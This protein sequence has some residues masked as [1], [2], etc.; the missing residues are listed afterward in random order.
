M[1]G[2]RKDAGGAEETPLK[3]I[4]L[5]AGLSMRFGSNKLLAV[6]RD[7]PLITWVF[8]AIKAAEA[9]EVLV[10]YHD[11]AVKAYA[12]SYG[13][14]VC[15]NPEPEE[16]QSRSV[17]EGL[18]CAGDAG[19]YM[20]LTG[21]QPLLTAETIIGMSRRFLDE[22]GKIM[23]AACRGRHGSPVIFDAVFCDEL[24][25]LSGDTGGRMVILGHPEAI[26]TYEIKEALELE[27]V[28]SIE[29]LSKLES[30]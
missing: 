13:F 18:R 20:F 6:F 12:L 9:G 29:D 14:N 10:V 24:F 2:F 8:E 17:R 28:D 22:P 11:E 30:I 26:V 5:A 4:V 16:G 25:A 1:S 19:A 27:D 21:D 7:K 15:F 23:M 3:I